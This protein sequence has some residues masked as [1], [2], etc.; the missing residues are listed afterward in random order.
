MRAK[1]LRLA[2]GGPLAYEMLARLPAAWVRRG[3]ALRRGTF[4]L[5][6]G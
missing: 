5:L 4:G 6:A 1:R 2:G 3:L